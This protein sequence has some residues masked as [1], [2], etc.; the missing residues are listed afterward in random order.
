MAT[1]RQFLAVIASACGLT[2]PIAWLLRPSPV[3]TMA[4]LFPV[5]KSDEEWR[6]A[7][8][9]EQYKVLQHQ[10]TERPFTSPLN[11]EKRPGTFQCAGCGRRLFDSAT[12]FESG[13]GW[14]SFWQ[15]LDRAV[16]TRLDRSWLMIRT[17][18]H[19][20][21]CGGHLGHVFEDGPAPT[22]LRYCL[23]GVALRFEA[24]DAERS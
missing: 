13:T 2:P 21:D 7:L 20:A 24:R 18:V 8:T 5:Q 9:A 11:R 19:C 3:E 22:G 16:G 6:R 15:P 23:N 10:A 17:E 12:K 1:R 4:G 14:P